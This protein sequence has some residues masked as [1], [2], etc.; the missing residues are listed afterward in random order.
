VTDKAI[1]ENFGENKLLRCFA[2]SI[3]LVTEGS[4]K[5]VDDLLDLIVIK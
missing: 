5:K 3:N 2:H 4:I 1:K